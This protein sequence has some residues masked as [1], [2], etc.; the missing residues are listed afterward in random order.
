VKHAKAPVA[1]AVREQAWPACASIA[2]VLQ[3]VSYR[4]QTLALAIKYHLDLG[5]FATNVES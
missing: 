4:M 5:I 2:C 1:S 3:F